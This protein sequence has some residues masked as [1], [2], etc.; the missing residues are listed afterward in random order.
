MTSMGNGSSGFGHGIL[1][2]RPLNSQLDIRKDA[3][4]LGQRKI[5]LPLFSPLLSCSVFE[6]CLVNPYAGMEHLL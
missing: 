2:I 3:R 5:A 4:A 1:V 6:T